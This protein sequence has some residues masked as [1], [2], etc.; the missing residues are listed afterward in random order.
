MNTC[1]ES[2]GDITTPRCVLEVSAADIRHN[3]EQLRRLCSARI[4]AVVK[5][6]GYGL[7]LV[8]YGKLLVDCGVDCLAVSGAE[9]G[10]LLRQSGIEADILVMTPPETE[11]C[12]CKI[13]TYGLIAAVGSLADILR[14]EAAAETTGA[15]CRMHVK[16]D[17]GFGRFG[18]MP[19]QALDTAQQ[20]KKC[21]RLRVEGVFTHCGVLQ[22]RQ[23]KAQH[24]VFMQAAEVL[25]QV[26]EKRLCR[27][28]CHSSLALKYPQFQLDAVRVG[29]ALLGRMAGAESLGLRP[30]GRLK[31]RVQDIHTMPAGSRPG[32]AGAERLAAATRVAVVAAGWQDGFGLERRRDAVCPRELFSQLYQLVA[33]AGRKRYVYYEGKTIPILGHGGM[34]FTLLNASGSELAVGDWVMMQVNPLLVPMQVRREYTEQRTE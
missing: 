19:E 27:H 15:E 9:E 26:L 33:G 8:P 4:I 24:T 32:Y 12:A 18:F 5:N 6:N 25:D 7:E 16:I 13:V 11:E 3:Y 17:T 20:L 1:C 21:R 14:L 29:S 10:I 31:G 2:V 34:N 23:V 30:V 22:P 28:F